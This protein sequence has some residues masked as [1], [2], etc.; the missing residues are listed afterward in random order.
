MHIFQLRLSIFILV[1]VS[2]FRPGH[3]ETVYC[4]AN[5]HVVCLTDVDDLW[6]A[7]YLQFPLPL[8]PFV[9]VVW[10]RV[11][12]LP[13][14]GIKIASPMQSHSGAAVNPSEQPT[15]CFYVSSSDI[16][17]DLCFEFE[18]KQGS[19]MLRWRIVKTSHF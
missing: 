5:F 14:L 17:H 11:G 8:S 13:A 19:L 2:N 12:M 18:N 9:A 6:S 10:E 1:A 16:F 3:S 7:R 15:S 4:Q